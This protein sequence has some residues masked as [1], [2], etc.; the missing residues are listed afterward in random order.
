MSQN[1]AVPSV[2]FLRSPSGS[3]TNTWRTNAGGTTGLFAG[4]D[5]TLVDVTDYIIC[6]APGVSPGAVYVTKLS[7]VADAPNDQNH[8][9]HYWLQFD[10]AGLATSPD[11]ILKVELRQGYV[12]EGAQGTL[13]HSTT[14]THSDFSGSRKAFRIDLDPTTEVSLITNYSDLYVRY[15]TFSVLEPDTF[16]VF[17]TWLEVPAPGSNGSNVKRFPK[18]A[19]LGDVRTGGSVNGSPLCQLLNP[20]GSGK[21]LVVYGLKIWGGGADGGSTTLCR[22]D[23]NSFRR[24]SNPLGV[25]AGGNTTAGKVIRLD[26]VNTD[27]IVGVLQAF[28]FTNEQFHEDGAGQSCEFAS[29]HFFEIRPGATV[30]DFPFVLREEGSF[31]L[32]VM[33]GSA[34]EVTWRFNASNYIVRLIVVWDEVVA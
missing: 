8:V 6:N 18:S 26:E 22:A 2:D 33:P 3:G 32:T 4:I 9:L 13:I 16:V 23:L 28:D 31:P 17:N 29:E 20:S 21:K 12:N 30:G 11:T 7:A 24:T 14:Y 5:E 15:Q 19:I 10:P 1:F 34:F 25:G 27:A